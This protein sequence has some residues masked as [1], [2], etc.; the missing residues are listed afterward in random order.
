MFGLEYR[1]DQDFVLFL[2]NL[3]V[4]LLQ[5]QVPMVVTIL[6]DQSQ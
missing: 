4:I 1:P 2:D 6:Y 5:L 3:F